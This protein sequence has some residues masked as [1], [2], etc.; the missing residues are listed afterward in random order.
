MADP[1]NSAPLSIP[2]LS[3]PVAISLIVSSLSQVVAAL[4]ALGVKLHVTDDQLTTIVG[5]AF[6]LVALGAAL[7]A[8]YRRY[9]SKVQP[10]AVTKAGAE[11]KA[12]TIATA[13]G[14][15]P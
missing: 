11:V 3:S 5:G 14:G 13:A 6:Q 10:L 1:T 15:A 8:L 9:T 12:S 4:A 7:Y 2:I